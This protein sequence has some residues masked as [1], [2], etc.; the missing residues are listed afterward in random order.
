MPVKKKPAKKLNLRT[1]LFIQYLTD[2]VQLDKEGKNTFGNQ[3][4]AYALAY[5]RQPD[6]IAAIGGT[7]SLNNA[8]VQSELES[9]A[10]SLDIGIKVR[11]ATLQHVAAGR[12]KKKVTT[13][14]YSVVKGKRKLASVSETTSP[15]TDRDSIRAIQVINRMTG[16]DAMQA[17]VQALAIREAK[18]IYN[19][20]VRPRGREK[21]AI[22]TV[23]AEQT[24]Y[25]A[26]FLSE[27]SKD[28]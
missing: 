25:A 18:D 4:R 26:E 3:T 17:G 19:R 13:R 8:K 23:Q 16:L 22:R 11:M 24:D 20:I 27:C 6:Q 10:E 1:R 21:P 2:Q 7:R 12:T 5:G 9:L 15:T 28:T 14:Q